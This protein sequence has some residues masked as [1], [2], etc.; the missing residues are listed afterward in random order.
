MPAFPRRG[1]RQVPA[2]TVVLRALHLRAHVRLERSG[3]NAGDV[4]SVIRPLVPATQK[5]EFV[6]KG[7]ELRPITRRPCH[8]RAYATPTVC[9]VHCLLVIWV[10]PQVSL[11]YQLLPKIECLN[12]AVWSSFLGPETPHTESLLSETIL[13]RLRNPF[14]GTRLHT[15]TTLATFPSASSEDAI[16][17]DIVNRFGENIIASRTAMMLDI[18]Y[19]TIILYTILTFPVVS[20]GID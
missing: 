10:A 15:N 3:A 14:H 5:K 19:K 11:A 6:L 9:V 7:N 20:E 8:L 4:G 12:L 18:G 17:A 13:C 2:A 16:V 1:D